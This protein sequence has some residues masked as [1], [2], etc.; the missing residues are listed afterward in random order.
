[1]VCV[2]RVRSLAWS[3]LVAAVAVGSLC[4]ASAAAAPAPK[5]LGQTTVQFKEA[6]PCNCSAWQLGDLNLANGSYGI[7][8][9]GVVVRSGVKVGHLTEVGDAFRAQTVHQTTATTGTV[10]S[11]GELHNIESR[12]DQIAT[13]YDRFPV[14]SGDRL[15]ARFDHVGSFFIEYTNAFYVTET[16]ADTIGGVTPP[17]V[18]GDPYNL[19]GPATTKQRINIE[20]VVEPDEDHDGYGDYSQDLCP[21]SPIGGG[22]CSGSLFGSNFEGIVGGAGG[23]G[24]DKLW[25]Q[26]ALGG[27]P[28]ARAERGVVVRWRVF[29]RST[30]DE[31]YQ[32]R[33]LS[34]NG[35]GGYT[36]TASSPQELVP[37][38]LAA[39]QANGQLGIYQTRLPVP[40]GGLVG[41]ATG[42]RFTIPAGAVG[43]LGASMSQ[44]TDG[45]DGTTYA[46]L[47]PMA[48]RVMGYDADIEPDVD[49]D[50]YGD[51]T[52]DSC[53]TS[54]TIHEGFCPPVPPAPP[55]GGGSGG[56]GGGDTVSNP[57]RSGPRS[58]ATTA[59]TISGLSLTPKTFQAKPLGPVAARGRTGTKIHLTLSSKA[60]VTLAVEARQGRRFKPVTKIVKLLNPGR[61]T[62]VFSGQYR[63]AGKLVDLAPGSY[64]LSVSAK[65]A[66]G[67]GPVKR[68]AFTVLPTG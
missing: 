6:G 3:V 63:H 30:F 68:V 54:A 23:A 40:A 41:L 13:F 44:L 43:V 52:Q 7:P 48:G 55:G 35:T 11:T 19:G 45:G 57:P 56:G 53:P 39:G 36:V 64:R 12:N 28:T 34:P 29:N 1:M 61:R 33:V 66:A 51:V 14:H 47:P 27:T 62:I 37:K 10:A 5:V 50:G 15:G 18:T 65:S 60:T 59:P 25:V 2:R 58:D 31:E 8:Y 17:L 67:T 24:S 22:P 20:A 21:G 46:S 49:G 26:T 32:L 42:P 9:D 38:N 4:A 16:A